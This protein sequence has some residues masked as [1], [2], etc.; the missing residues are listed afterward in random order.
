[1]QV[2]KLWRR[3]SLLLTKTWIVLV[4]VRLTLSFGSYRAVLRRIEALERRDNPCLSIGQLADAVDLT[5]RYV[6]RASC[7]T[8]ALALRYLAAREGVDC[9][10]RIGVKKQRNGSLEA[11]AWVTAE[12]TVIIGGRLEDI[13][14]FT[15]II[16]L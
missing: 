13:D 10:I 15:P 16:D 3:H 6:P 4:G 1:M 2:S 11:H 12:E 5:S 8:Q 9:T 14:A 7:L